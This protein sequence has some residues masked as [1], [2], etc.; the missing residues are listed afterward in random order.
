MKAI[1][2]TWLLGF[3]IVFIGN[4][5]LQSLAL[6]T[7]EQKQ[8]LM[9]AQDSVVMEKEG[10]FTGWADPHTVEI[11]ID[12]ESMAFQVAKDV[13]KYFDNIED[14]DLVCFKYVDKPVEND[15]SVEQLLLTEIHKIK[16]NIE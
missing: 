14:K 5:D 1:A 6:Y 15:F 7:K 13:E 16:V 4:L 10:V 9:Q 2:I 3:S 12:E 8:I 11:R